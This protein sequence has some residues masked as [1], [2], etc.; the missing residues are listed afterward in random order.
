MRRPI[1]MK[2]KR[3]FSFSFEFHFVFILFNDRNFLSVLNGW[4]VTFCGLLEENDE[5]FKLVHKVKVI[6]FCSTKRRYTL[7]VG[8]YR[9]S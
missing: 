7:N 3:L 9:G 4:K 6:Y 5:Y 8:G 2:I 1:E